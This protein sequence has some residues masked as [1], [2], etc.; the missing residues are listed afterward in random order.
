MKR[1][2]IYENYTDQDTNTDHTKNT[3]MIEMVK[4]YIDKFYIQMGEMS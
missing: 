1:R 4:K 3:K 2:I